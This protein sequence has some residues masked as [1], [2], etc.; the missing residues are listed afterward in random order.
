MLHTVNV[1]LA[2]TILHGPTAMILVPAAVTKHDILLLG[3]VAL[4]LRL[5]CLAVDLS[6]RPV[7]LLRS[8][9]LLLR[10]VNH[11]WLC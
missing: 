4:L 2:C 5:V 3:P 1:C 9:A 8:V 11:L 10:P 7:T 6:L